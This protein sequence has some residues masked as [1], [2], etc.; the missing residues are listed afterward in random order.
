MDA[1]VRAALAKWPNVPDCYDWLSLD[2]RGHWRLGQERQ[3]ITN[4]TMNA[5]I[6]RNYD[7][8]DQ[9]RWLF[10]NGPQ[11]V[12]VALEYT[13]WVWQIVPAG[14]KLA[15]CNHVGRLAAA[16]Q[17]MWLD[18]R[19]RFLVEADGMLGVLHDHDVAALVDLLVDQEG[20]APNPE[21]LARTLENFGTDGN[22]QLWV[23][24]NQEQR[25]RVE[26]IASHE[27][28]QQFGF[29]PHPVAAPASGLTS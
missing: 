3:S 16:P 4:P 28:A 13:P 18:E 17:A 1:S 7:H 27:V 2:Q 8:D 15:L 14:D 29:E 20:R 22:S 9:G 10:Q 26:A 25:L 12:F 19:G 5:F 24:W 21:E 23:D 11:R 6:G